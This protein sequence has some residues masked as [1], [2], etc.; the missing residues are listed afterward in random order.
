MWQATIYG[1]DGAP[2]TT[3]YA[4]TRADARRWAQRFAG[5]GEG[6]AVSRVVAA[7]GSM[8]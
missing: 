8:S 1:R 3:S 7:A 5:P 2:V 6:Y 4:A